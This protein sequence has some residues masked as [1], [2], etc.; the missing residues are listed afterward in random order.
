[1]KYIYKDYR[2]KIY[3]VS[4]NEEKTVPEDITTYQVNSI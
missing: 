1:M 2:L 4:T 3:I